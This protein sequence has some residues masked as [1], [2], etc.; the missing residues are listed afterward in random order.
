MIGETNAI[1][2]L[3]PLSDD[4]FRLPYLL[5]V[6]PSAEFNTEASKHKLLSLNLQADDGPRVNYA[7]PGDVVGGNIL[8]HHGESGLQE[9][10]LK[11]ACWIDIENHTSVSYCI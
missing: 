10:L 6:R 1:V 3:T 8:D 7:T 11:V 9:K 2:L 4:Q 5:E